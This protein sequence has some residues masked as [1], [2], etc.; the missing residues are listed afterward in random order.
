MATKSNRPKL[1]DSEAKDLVRKLA[2]RCCSLH[3]I[4]GTLQS[5]GANVKYLDNYI[6][7]VMKEISMEPGEILPQI[8][9]GY[10]VTLTAIDEAIERARAN[11]LAGLEAKLLASR[12][13]CLSNLIRWEQVHQIS[14]LAKA[15]AATDP[16]ATA[17][18][19]AKAWGQ[20]Q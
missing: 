11:G 6:T 12:Q 7:E 2:A 17:V 16:M 9:H 14:G 19:L 4:R 5:S 8:R 3:T 15:T 13:Q 18:V 20:G 10:S 1:S